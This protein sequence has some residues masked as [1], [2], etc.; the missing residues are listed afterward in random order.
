M[1]HERRRL[2]G[3]LKL[4]LAGGILVYLFYSLR[5]EDVFERLL[6]EQKIWRY[7]ALAQALI[8]A[9]FAL[10]YV[11]WYV[12][13]RA[14]EIPFELRDAFRLG[15]MGLMLSQVSLGSVGGD[16]F[17]AIAVAREQPGKKTEAVA[18]VVID[19]VVGL[20]AI[21]LVASAG[22]VAAGGGQL[23]SPLIHSLSIFIM[24][25]T[26]A[27]AL[28]IAILMTPAATG[29]GVQQWCA[30]L[31]LAGHTLARLTGAAAAYRNERRYLF[32]AIGIACV[33]HTLFVLGIYS[34]GQG[35]PVRQPSLALT[36]LVGPMAL[37][38]G[39][40][41]I[42]PG[43]LGTLEGAMDELYRAVGSQPGDG[44]LVALTYRVMTYVIVAIGAAYYLSAKRSIDTVMVEAEQR[45][46]DLIEELEHPGNSAGQPA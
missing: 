30:S 7:F 10:N 44:L 31:P 43:G 6:A 14:L 23:N 29:P 15:S 22:S 37:C 28:G 16:L 13:V 20:F 46:D 38:A 32:A 2:I 9:G 25:M 26:L 19:R 33:T 8:L 12:L 3:A 4:A 36:F 24:M 17:K 1:L 41:P 27:G 42:T 18:T 5:G 21:L 45:G 39:A 35:L 11:R 34:I 40:L